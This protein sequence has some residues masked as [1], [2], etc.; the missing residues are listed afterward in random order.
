MKF[1]TTFGPLFILLVTVSAIPV[2][3]IEKMITKRTC[4]TLKGEE[5]QICQDAC[6]AL[7]VRPHL[8]MHI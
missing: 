5:L 3:P 2:A 6:V 1:T 7:C 8:K 4:G